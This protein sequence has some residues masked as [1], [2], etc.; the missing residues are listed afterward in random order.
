MKHN[1]FFT[2][3][4][5]TNF[6]KML[7]VT[8]SLSIRNERAWVIINLSSIILVSVFAYAY[9]TYSK[10]YE[11]LPPQLA[12]FLLV[13]AF[14]TGAYFAI[15]LS[16]LK[17]TS[18]LKRIKF[19][20]IKRSSIIFSFIICASFFTLVSSL[21]SILWLFIMSKFQLQINFV[22]M[23]NLLWWNWLWYLIVLVFIEIAI[24]CLS[25]IV[26][27][28]LKGKL[29]RTSVPLVVILISLIMSD[30]AIP[31]LIGGKNWFLNYFGYLCITKYMVWILLITSSFS[32]IDFGGI[33]QVVQS[34][35]SFMFLNNLY[36]LITISIIVLGLLI[37]LSIRFFK[38]K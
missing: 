28:L 38:W 26:M 17:D 30:V 1:N 19:V 22:Y 4:N 7:S 20:G 8:F 2:K 31:S 37:Y 27:D 5:L 9:S 11:L 33:E 36:A 21:L 15:F 16:N 24:L 23:S 35:K 6:K 29:I 12:S 25:V 3:S 34:K 10:T 18:I 13:P 14:I 32:F